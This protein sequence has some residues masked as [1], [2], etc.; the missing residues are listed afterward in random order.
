MNNWKKNRANR[1]H[2]SKMPFVFQ[3][4][5]KLSVFL[6]IEKWT[7]E[8]FRVYTHFY[9]V[10]CSR[11]IDLSELTASWCCC[12]AGATPAFRSSHCFFR[13][14]TF[15]APSLNRAIVMVTLGIGY[16]IEK[17]EWWF[18]NRKTEKAVSLLKFCKKAIEKSSWGSTLK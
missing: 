12:N 15:N 18:K 11:D 14:Q 2:K 4:R 6:I 3:I 5:F 10:V 16:L 13:L 9:S 8:W 17:K 1:S 7:H